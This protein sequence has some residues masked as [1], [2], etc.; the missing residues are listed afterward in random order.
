M[1][2]GADTQ[3]GF[4][5]RPQSANAAVKIVAPEHRPATP[6]SPS[7]RKD[8]TQR[9]CRNILIYGS[10][11]FQDKG[12]IYYH[13][14][15]QDVSPPQDRPDSPASA[16]FSANAPVFIPKS[17]LSVRSS[18]PQSVQ[19]QSETFVPTPPLT[20]TSDDY[21]EHDPYDPYYYPPDLHGEA[22]TDELAAKMQAMETNVYDMSVDPHQMGL[23]AEY[24]SMSAFYPHPQPTYVQQPL[25]YHLYTRPLPSL[26]TR[27]YFIP[28][29]VREELQRRS[30]IIR[31]APMPGLNL[32]EDLQGYHSIVPLEP[33][34][35]EKRKFGNWSTVVYRAINEKDGVPYALRRMES[36]RIPHVTAFAAIEAWNKIRHPNIVSV[37]E[38]FTTRA[39]N[40]NSL[41]VV[42][43]YYANAQTLYDAYVKPKAPSF[44]NG[45][46]QQQSQL[47][48]EHT[49]WSFI[50]QIASAIKAV[51]ERGMAVRAVDPTKILVTDKNRVRLGSC[52]ILDALTWE[53]PVDVAI[54]QMED[55]A[56]FGAIIVTLC[57]Q[58]VAA[59]HTNNL[60]KA[61]DTLGRTYSNDVKKIIVWLYGKPGPH[62]TIENFLDVIG[63]RVVAEMDEMQTSVDRLQA[64]L[65]N[66]LENARLVRLLAKMG[67]IN[68]RPEFARE[69]RWSETG[70]RYIIK[71]F[72][73]YVFHQVDENGNPV[74]NLTHV[75]TCLNKLDAGTDERIMLIS[76]DEQSC[77][78]V[79]YKDIKGFIDS[80]FSDLATAATSGRM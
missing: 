48:P 20:A 70:D 54:F 37:K 8:S 78:V 36:Y 32:P 60:A 69:P 16:A 3:N 13:P 59:S 18:T 30:E 31:T 46:L 26:F 64:E 71:L 47:L 28:D 33:L 24:D 10:C 35:G 62:K 11:K 14:P 40:D 22:S 42:Y 6:K 25:N 66:E 61:L 67:F 52:G 41:V 58:N 76:R 56:R 51:H 80:A 74:I 73:D 43:D 4:F 29:D 12:C 63:S 44:V 45:R 7:S 2:A 75:L 34:V 53:A 21:T 27:N 57:C 39:F 38:A 79:S 77:L 5:W 1:Q 49:L 72:R 55:L 50:V 17:T 9:Q 19:A 23:S 15:T 68:E 65:M